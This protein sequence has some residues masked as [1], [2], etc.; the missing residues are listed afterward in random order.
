MS[1]EPI[2]L[3]SSYSGPEGSQCV[4]VAALPRTVHVRDSKRTNGPELAVGAPAW[5]AFITYASGT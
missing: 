4:E 2:W 1:A 5:A 3:K